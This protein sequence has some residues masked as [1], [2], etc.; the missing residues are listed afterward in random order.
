MNLIALHRIERKGGPVLPGASFVELDAKEADWLVAEGAAKVAPTQEPAVEAMTSA[1][2]DAL[3][4]AA[5][6]LHTF[7]AIPKA[8]P[9]PK[10]SRK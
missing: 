8:A 1:R 10:V 6:P 4:A 2:A 7:A 5:N 9:A 3:V